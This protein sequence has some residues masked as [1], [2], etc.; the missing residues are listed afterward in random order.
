MLSFILLCLSCLLFVP[1]IM[2]LYKNPTIKGRYILIIALIIQTIITCWSDISTSY[3]REINVRA[4]RWDLICIYLVSLPVLFYF[5]YINNISNFLTLKTIFLIAVAVLCF[6]N[7]VV[8]KREF[9][10][11]SKK[12]THYDLVNI[13][14]SFWHI[15]VGYIIFNVINSNIKKKYST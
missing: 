15:L 2:L 5:L 11:L 10:I 1:S 8:W 6:I 13:N 14:H 3:N 12:G 7:S 4:L 9:P